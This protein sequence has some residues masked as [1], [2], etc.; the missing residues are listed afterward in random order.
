MGFRGQ[1][2]QI[3]TMRTFLMNT[4]AM[5]MGCEICSMMFRRAYYTIAQTLTTYDEYGEPRPISSDLV[6]MILTDRSQY[7]ARISSRYDDLRAACEEMRK[8]P[9]S[10]LQDANVEAAVAPFIKGAKVLDLA[11]GTGYY[12]KKFLDG[13]QSRLSVLT[14]QKPWYMLRTQR[15][16]IPID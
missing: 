2:V 9:I 3:S 11:C 12:S 1:D 4:I 7:R 8:L 6:D 15:Q 5:E 13:A 14:S 16:R 10:V